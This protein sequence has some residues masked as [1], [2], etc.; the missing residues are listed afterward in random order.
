MRVPLPAVNGPANGAANSLQIRCL[1]CGNWT[2]YGK[3]VAEGWTYDPKGKPF[4][5]YYCADDSKERDRIQ[6]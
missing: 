6:S 3:A 1:T 2:T 5:A 4:E